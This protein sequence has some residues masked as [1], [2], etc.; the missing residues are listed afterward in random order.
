MSVSPEL[1]LIG[2]AL[3]LSACRLNFLTRYSHSPSESTNTCARRGLPNA[4]PIKMEMLT[5][6]PSTSDVPLIRHSASP[7]RNSARVT[8]KFSG[9]DAILTSSDEVPPD[10]R[11]VSLKERVAG[12]IEN[13]KVAVAVVAFVN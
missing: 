8:V 13:V 11:T 12:C 6:G 9:M 1:D 2:T 5:T 10:P 4:L 3:I 7:V